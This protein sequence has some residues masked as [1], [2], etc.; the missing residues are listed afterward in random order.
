MRNVFDQH[1]QPENRITHAFL[2]A[3]NED[4]RLLESFLRD[5]LKVKPPVA[6]KSLT[7]LEQQYPGEEEVGEEDSD[8][9]GIPDGWIVDDEGWCVLIEC[10]VIAR[11]GSDQIRRHRRT[12]ERRGFQNITVVAIT[13]R[14]ETGL[15]QLNRRLLTRLCACQRE[16]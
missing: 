4:R 1:S 16:Q 11:L 13:P 15:A 2:T 12:A 8:R 7:V 10:K 6:A 9:R 3:L 5:V 14:R